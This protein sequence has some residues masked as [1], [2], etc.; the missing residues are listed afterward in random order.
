MTSKQTT[1]ASPLKRLKTFK[2]RAK[3]ASLLVL[4]TRR[5]RRLR[6]VSDYLG[7]AP[8]LGY[9]GWVNQ[10]NLGDEALYDAYCELFPK[11]ALL[12]LT[13]PLPVEFW[14]H[15]GLIR[16]GNRFNAVVV[17]GGT[18]I[19][20]WGYL[21]RIE[22]AQSDGIPTYVFGTGVLDLDLYSSHRPDGPWKESRDR[23][24]ACIA[25]AQSVAVRGPRSAASLLTMGI[26]DVSI[27]GDP[28]LSVCNPPDT[29]RAIGPKRV[30]INIGN[31]GAA[32]GD[33]DSSDSLAVEVIHQL[34]ARG[35]TVDAFGMH[36]SDLE[37]IQKLKRELGAPIQDIWFEPDSTVS[38]LSKLDQYEF[39]LS[40]KLHGTVLACGLGIPNISLAY[41]PKCLD[42][43]E[44]MDALPLA[45]RLDQVNAEKVLEVFD[46]TV[47][48]YSLISGSLI[49]RTRHWQSIQ[50]EAADVV[51]TNILASS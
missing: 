51:T 4:G 16:R 35:W 19:N 1:D 10:H 38:F 3:S 46:S 49:K 45:L 7:Q 50:R 15:A 48:D 28:A 2:N 18:L 31:I 21:R 9:V 40:Q 30:A 36:R 22:R 41:D 14:L 42:F 5:A 37:R 39:V 43:M 20:H 13:R 24:A 17:G 44:T 26:K 32:W 23:W 27:V 34:V 6:H 11:F 12:A 47:N 33:A 29:P 8:A 25:A